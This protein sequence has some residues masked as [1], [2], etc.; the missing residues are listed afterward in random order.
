MLSD[1]IRT[2][3]YGCPDKRFNNGSCFC[4]KK[5]EVAQPGKAM[6]C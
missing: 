2:M 4:S 3:L 5:A 1:L 6:D